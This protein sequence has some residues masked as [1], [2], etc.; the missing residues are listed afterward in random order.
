M[1]FKQILEQRSRQ[2]DLEA[3]KFKDALVAKEAL[4][5]MPNT[6]INKCYSELSIH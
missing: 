6:L 1:L 5:N 2:K 3:W 4:H